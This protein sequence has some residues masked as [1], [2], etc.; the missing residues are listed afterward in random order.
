MKLRKLVLVS[1][2][3]LTIFT[4]GAVSA[5]EN[6]TDDALA[7]DD[8][9]QESSNEEIQT[10]EILE[11]NEK[12]EALSLNDSNM[13]VDFVKQSNDGSIKKITPET[14]LYVNDHDSDYVRAKFPSTVTGSLSL[15]IDGK[16]MS[17]KEIS[18]KTHYLFINTRSYNLTEG[19]HTW[20]L[21]YSG[22]DEYNPSSQNGTFVLNPASETFVKK[23]PDM[24]VYVVTKDGDGIIYAIDENKDLSVKNTKTDYF[25]VKFAKEVSGT[26]YLYIDGKLKATKKISKKTH[27][28]FANAENYNLKVGSHSWK[29]VYSGDDE[30]NSTA[31]KGT[32]TLNLNS[33]K[34]R[35]NKIATSL[36]VPKTKT[37]KLSVKT[38]K[39]TVTLKANKKALKKV[40]LSLTL[41]GKKYKKTFYAKTNSKGQATFKITGLTKKGTYSG[42]VNY[43]GSKTY[44]SIGYKLTVKNQKSKSKF[45]RG[46]VIKNKGD[47]YIINN[48]ITA[49]I[50]AKVDVSEVYRLL[51][52]F[53]SQKGVWQLDKNNQ[54]TTFFNTNA[55][56]TLCVLKVDDELEKVAEKRAEEAYQQFNK[57]NKL[58]HTRPDG[59]DCFTAYP[60]GL[61]NYGENLALGYTTPKQVMEAWKE[62][63]E[64]YEKQGHRRNM[65]DPEFNCVGI[66]AYKMNGIIVWAQSFGLRAEI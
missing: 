32:Y 37:F 29:I 17:E 38:K 45:I 23:T 31:Q 64:P 52:D 2:I 16:L 19:A 1:L 34:V 27:Y 14:D 13:N 54:N 51:N 63:N 4:L 55:S 66:G 47:D 12:E 21:T 35:S 44:K 56:N 24:N 48:T 50:N 20:K 22:D 25:K 9:I 61:G 62:I 30:Y 40:K 41:K 57:T 10:D 58:T 53:R 46:A 36:S 43:K 15:F 26:L 3:L 8:S 49:N 5:S 18:A 59:T 6:I 7:A 11:S 28:F 39:Y 33:Q 60:D 65:L 42:S